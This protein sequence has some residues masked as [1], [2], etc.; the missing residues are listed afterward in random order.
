METSEICYNTGLRT[1]N[2]YIPAFLLSGDLLLPTYVGKE[3]E[4][5]YD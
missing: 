1:L 3:V 5:D 2:M 4:V